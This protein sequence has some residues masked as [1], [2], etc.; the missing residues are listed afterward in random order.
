MERLFRISIS[1]I[2]KRAAAFILLLAL[3]LSL[4]AC[5]KKYKDGTYSGEYVDDDKE[6]TVVEI[7]IKDDKIIDAKLTEYDQSGSLKDENYGK[8]GGEV[9]WTAAQLSLQEAAKY[10]E[11]LVETQDIDEV[12]ALSGATVS[13]LRFKLAFKEALKNAK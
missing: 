8:E 4:T 6:R 12:D 1:K 13:Y 10:P 7:T 3:A 11:K 9:S 2:L 5:G